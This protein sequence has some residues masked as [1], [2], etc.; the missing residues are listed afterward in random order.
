MSKE[1][2]KQC[3]YCGEK[4][5]LNIKRPD[6]LSKVDKNVKPQ[7]YC[8]RCGASAGTYH[9]VEK[10]IAAWNTRAKENI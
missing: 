10:A 9:T 1:K 2:L 5:L 3:P 4:H 7:V 8:C 6:P